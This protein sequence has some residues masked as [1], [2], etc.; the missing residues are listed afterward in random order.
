M[1]S[2]VTVNDKYLAQLEDDDVPHF[3][4]FHVTWSK[5]CLRVAPVW[6]KI[7]DHFNNMQN[8]EWEPSTTRIIHS[9][10]MLLILLINSP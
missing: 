2:A 4:F 3:I 5:F 1:L 8:Q 9:C 6:E 10:F 7:A